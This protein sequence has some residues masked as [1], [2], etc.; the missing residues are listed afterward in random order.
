MFVF[1]CALISVLAQ[2]SSSKLRFYEKEL[3]SWIRDSNQVKRTPQDYISE[4][5]V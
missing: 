3:D 1:I 4:L 5:T 2:K